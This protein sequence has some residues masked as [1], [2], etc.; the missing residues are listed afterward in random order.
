VGVQHAFERRDVGAIAEWNGP[1]FDWDAA[2]KNSL[3][4]GA[5]NAYAQLGWRMPLGP[6]TAMRFSAS[7]G[8][9]VLLFEKVST[10]VGQVNPDV[11]IGL[12]EVIFARENGRDL[13]VC[14]ADFALP[15]TQLRGWPFFYPQWR[16]TVTHRF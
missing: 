14:F 5:A 1:W 6:T 16:S 9:T 11:G 4:V 15:V 7:A 13:S 8:L 12:G 2:R 3:D 10:R